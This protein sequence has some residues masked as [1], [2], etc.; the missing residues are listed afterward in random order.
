M[1]W[2]TLLGGLSNSGAK[3]A[4]GAADDA[5]DLLE[6]SADDAARSVGSYTDDAERN[7]PRYA[8]NDPTKLHIKGYEWRGKGNI[9]SKW[10]NWY[11][12]DTKEWLRPDLNHPESVKP[13]WDY[14]SPDGKVYRIFPDGTYEL[15]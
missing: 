4:A 12:P 10:G 9:G 1:T 7:I 15:K 14:G 3:G 6:D 13:H 11:N 5:A 8:G 2:M